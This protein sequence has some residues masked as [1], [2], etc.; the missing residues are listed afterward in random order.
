MVPAPGPPKFH[1]S[2]RDLNVEN[3]NLP[4]VITAPVPETAAEVGLYSSE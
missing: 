4:A 1:P 3:K 2:T